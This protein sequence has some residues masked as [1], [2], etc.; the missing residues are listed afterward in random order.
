MPRRAGGGLAFILSAIDRG[1][2]DFSGMGSGIDLPAYV[3]PGPGMEASGM[4]RGGKVLTP[5]ARFTRIPLVHAAWRQHTEAPEN[6]FLRRSR[7]M[8]VRPPQPRLRQE[9]GRRT[10]ALTNVEGVWRSGRV[11]FVQHSRV[12]IPM[13]VSTKHRLLPVILIANDL[14]SGDVVFYADE[15]WT[16]DLGNAR[17]A[18]DQASADVLEAAGARSVGQQHVVDA[19]LIE[20]EPTRD[21]PRPR[22]FRERFRTTGPTIYPHLARRADAPAQAAAVSE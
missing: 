8:E 5:L 9:G 1:A 6:D 19:Y 15:G 12:R 10:S 18:P 2:F 14:R 20:V 17:V 4:S 21:G 11:A 7:I 16:R 22:H 3:N 13:S